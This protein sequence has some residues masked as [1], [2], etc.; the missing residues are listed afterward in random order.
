M[1]DP[2]LVHRA[3]QAYLG[4]LLARQGRIGTG[5]VVAGDAG[6]DGFACLRPL[7]FADPVHQAI[8]AAL[9]G[10]DLEGRASWPA[11][12]NGSAVCCPGCCARVPGRPAPTWPACPA[13]ARTRPICPPTPP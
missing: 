8:Y 2:D 13:C 7:D 6:P 1:T 11:C 9:A 5:A 10:Q 4:A 3:E 12:T